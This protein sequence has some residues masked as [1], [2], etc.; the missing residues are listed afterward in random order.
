M[1]SQNWFQYVRFSFLFAFVNAV[2]VNGTH[3]PCCVTARSGNLLLHLLG[4]ISYI[5]WL[6]DVIFTFSWP[7]TCHFS[8]SSCQSILF[9]SFCLRQDIVLSRPSLQLLNLWLLKVMLSCINDGVMTIK[10]EHQTTGKAH[11]IWSDKSSFTLIPTSEEFTFGE[12][13]RKPTIQ[14]AWFQ[15][16]NTGEVLWWFGQLYHGTVSCSFHYHPSWQNYCK[17]VY[18][19]VR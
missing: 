3:E 10:P 7:L 6:P 13:P 9:F 1:R 5:Q 11:M 8:C 18:G 15:Q 19:Q 2:D 12:H 16:W 4:S 14:N 17:G